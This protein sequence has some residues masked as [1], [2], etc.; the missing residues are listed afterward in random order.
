MNRIPLILLLLFLNNLIIGLII[1]LWGTFLLKKTV[2]IYS[3]TEKLK[4]SS[5]KSRTH[6]PIKYLIDNNWT[7]TTCHFRDKN[8]NY[9]FLKITFCRWCLRIHSSMMFRLPI[10]LSSNAVNNHAI[11]QFTSRNIQQCRWTVGYYP[12]E[13][14]FRE[15]LGNC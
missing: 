4:L 2:D 6:A 11:Q 14:R 8:P 10:D 12:A 9:Q 3:D 7:T 1:S 5:N 15:V 13:T